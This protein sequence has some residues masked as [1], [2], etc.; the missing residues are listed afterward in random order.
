MD[1]TS[2]KM[3]SLKIVPNSGEQRQYS[4]HL[5]IKLNGLK[6]HN[7][8]QSMKECFMIHKSTNF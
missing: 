1:L 6:N 7:A 5:R 2:E 3:L 4:K 8:R